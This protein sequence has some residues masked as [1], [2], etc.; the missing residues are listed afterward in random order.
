M[1][2]H[3]SHFQFGSFIGGLC[4]VVLLQ[5]YLAKLKKVR[6][7]GLQTPLPMKPIEKKFYFSKSSTLHGYSVGNTDIRIIF[8]IHF[9][10]LFYRSTKSDGGMNIRRNSVAKK[11]LNISAG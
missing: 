8:L 2:K 7:S 1:T 9:P 6:T 4:L 11:M 10:Y 3:H 5:C